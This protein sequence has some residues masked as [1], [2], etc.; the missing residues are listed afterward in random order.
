MAAQPLVRRGCR[1][2]VGDGKQIKVWK[3]KWIPSP[4][5]YKVI[6][7]KRLPGQILWVSDLIDEDNKEWKKDP[8]N[9]CFL[10][11]DTVAILSIPLSVT[12]ARDRVL[13][14]ETKNGRITVKSAYRLAQAEKWDNVMV[15]GSNQSPMKQTWKCLWQL[16]VPNKVRHFA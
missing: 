15:E 13:W 2:Q 4:Q 10:P 9:Q 16:N 5:T 7:P 14:A 1:W 6:S 8:V 11:Q 12:G 3:D